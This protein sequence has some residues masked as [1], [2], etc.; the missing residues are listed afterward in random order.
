MKKI[1]VFMALAFYALSISGQDTV[2]GVYPYYHYNWYEYRPQGIMHDDVPVCVLLHND[3]LLEFSQDSSFFIFSSYAPEIA[4]QFGIDSQLVVEGLS[5]SYST[6]FPLDYYIS[7]FCCVELNGHYI[8][9]LDSNNIYNIKPSNITAHFNVYDKEMN[10]MYSQS[11]RRSNFCPARYIALGN[12]NNH[13]IIW[14]RTQNNHYIPL[15]VP[16]VEIFFDNPITLSD[17]FFVSVTY[18]HDSSEAMHLGPV[19]LSTAEKHPLGG[20]TFVQPWE[21][22]LYRDTLYTGIWHEE[23]YGRHTTGLFPII[24]RDG[25]TC[26]QVRNVEFFKGSATQFFLR[27]Q[28]GVNH[29]DWQVSLCPDG[30]DPADGALFSCSDPITQLITVDPDSHY[31]AYVRARCRFA[32]DEWGPWS[33]PVSIWLN[34]PTEAISGSPAAPAVTLSPNPAAESVTVS[35]DGAAITL[36]EVFAQ[37]G[38]RF[39]SI[40][41]DGAQSLAVDTSRWPQ[42][43]YMLRIHTTRGVA[44]RKLAVQR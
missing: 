37:D 38:A 11:L 1:I 6:G 39:S 10:L 22:R 42:G 4:V 20:T 3:G 16:V 44:T 25:D 18:T 41:T 8:G 5:F 13:D 43:S 12:D 30:T 33:D 26:P 23:D 2:F 28:R 14:D 21:R 19:V 24:R 9:I 27:W 40:Q 17:T 15:F 32:R 31:T 35:A 7:A 36:V 29:H 34:E